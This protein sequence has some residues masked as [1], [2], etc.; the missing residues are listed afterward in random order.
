MSETV[1]HIPAL[2][3]ECID[4]LNI[5]PNGVYVDVTFG[6]GGH[7]RA[8]ME[9]LD[10][11]GHL[12]GFDQD[13]D[14][15]A[16]AIDDKRFTFVY[17]NFAYIS[18]FLRYHKVKQVDGI[19]ADLGVSFHHFDESDRGFSFRFDGTL[20]MRMNRKSENDARKVIATYDEERLADI[21]YLYGELKSSRKIASAIVKARAKNPINT[22]GDLLEVI[23]PFIKP[24]Q[25]KK[26]LAQVFQALRIEVNNEIDVLKSLL[27]QSIKVLKPGGRLVILTY[28]SLEDRLVK[29]FLKSG[30]IEGKVEKDFFGKVNSPFR[31]I[32]NK[33]I[34]ASDEE[35]ER[36]PRARSAKLR[37]AEKI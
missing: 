28:H 14:A 3:N 36:N 33:V 4:G 35:V 26:E 5:K 9:N 27:Q 13:Q 17:S 34:V 11:N 20:D 6:G 32:N 24:T 7:S 25:E 29:N 30:N 19:L 16:N 21:L 22:T 23:K 37:I 31:L 15:I 12:Y 1:Y 2:L 10:K 8:I 18:N